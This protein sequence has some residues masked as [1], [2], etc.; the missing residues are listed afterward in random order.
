MKIWLQEIIYSSI[1]FS[2]AQYIRDVYSDES[3]SSYFPWLLWRSVFM[4]IFGY[5]FASSV[6]RF[7]THSR[8]LVESDN[9]EG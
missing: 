7:F 3:S 4:F 9:N 8:S 1:C 5:T 2:I 6:F